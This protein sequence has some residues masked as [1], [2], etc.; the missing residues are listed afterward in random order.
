MPHRQISER[1]D[2]NHSGTEYHSGCALDKGGSSYG[3]GGGNNGGDAEMGVMGRQGRSCR[4]EGTSSMSAVGSGNGSSWGAGVAR[5]LRSFRRREGE[6][7]K[8][9]SSNN[10]SCLALKT[11]VGTDGAP[12]RASRAVLR[13]RRGVVRM[14]VV[15]VVAFAAC[16]LP[17][18]AR[19]MWQYWSPTYRG[20][21]PLSSLLTPLTF[22]VSYANSGI[23][24]LLYAFMSRNFRKGMKELLRC[25]GTRRGGGA[26]ASSVGGGGNTLVAGG[27]G[28]R[29]NRQS[30]CGTGC[31]SVSFGRKNGTRSLRRNGSTSEENESIFFDDHPNGP[32]SGHGKTELS[33]SKLQNTESNG[34]SRQLTTLDGTDYANSTTVSLGSSDGES[35]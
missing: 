34:I 3:E 22:L 5:K 20:N 30:Q 24:P 32:E 18:H 1:R 11:N 17:L 31:D 9:R 16:N 15:V 13:A 25:S 2:V 19:K 10:R 28:A 29:W 4:W 8:N 6:N 23:N 27:R 21:S 35:G 7:A 33:R 12:P 26:G 14:L